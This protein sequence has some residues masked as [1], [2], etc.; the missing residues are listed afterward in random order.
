LLF[1]LINFNLD[2]YDEKNLKVETVE[3][4]SKQNLLVIKA[5]SGRQESSEYITALNTDQ[6]VLKDYNDP[7]V[8]IVSISTN[9]YDI[10]LEDK[11]PER[12][13]KFYTEHYQ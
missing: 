8:S 4:N 9:N 7:S 12:Y 5:F 6:K 13:L 2:N 3:I 10:L 11:S 1:N